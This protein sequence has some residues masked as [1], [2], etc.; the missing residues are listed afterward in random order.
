MR[1]KIG[2]RNDG[3]FVAAEAELAYQAG[4]FAGSPVRRR[5]HVRLRA[6]RHRQRQG[7]GLRRG[8]QPA[9]GG[10]LP[11]AGRADLRVRRGVRGGRPG[12]GSSGSTRSSCASRTPPGRAPRPPTARNSARSALSQ[13][14]EAAKAHEHWRTPL[15]KNQGRGI[16]SGL[17]VQRRRRD[18]RVAA[19]QRGR[20]PV[21]HRRHARHRRPARLAVHD[22]GRGAGRGAR[23]HPRAD[24]RHRPARLQHADRRQPLHLLQ[25]HG[26]GGG[27]ARGEARGL[28]ARRQ[29]VGAAR[30]RGRVPQGRRAPRRPQRRQARAA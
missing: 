23:S 2:A 13:T 8:H 20:H 19:A 26:H 10:R 3:R 4:A 14:L 12:R 21:A 15:A 30:G 9:Q 29:A 24:R 22:G 18:L 6:L 17:L 5:R 11:R 7:G 25:R 27:R 16:A 28:Q 1:V